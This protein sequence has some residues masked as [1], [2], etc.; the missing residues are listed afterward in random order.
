MPRPIGAAAFVV[1]IPVKAKDEPLYLRSIDSINNSILRLK[2]ITNHEP[3]NVEVGATPV[4]NRHN[5]LPSIN[6]KHRWIDS[7]LSKSSISRLVPL[8]SRETASTTFS[9][10]KK[11]VL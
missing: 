2:P 3:N 4:T 8:T 9:K 10:E 11:K 5:S 6:Q 1:Q 7:K